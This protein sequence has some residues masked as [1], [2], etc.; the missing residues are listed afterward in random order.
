[1]PDLEGRLTRGG[2]GSGRLR[3]LEGEE[4][5]E[6]PDS[7]NSNRNLA[8]RRR[9]RGSSARPCSAREGGA[10]GGRPEVEPTQRFLI[11]CAFRR[12]R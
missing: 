8:G 2:E 6:S 10:L 9:W 12:Y 1:V 11:S 3:H 7:I 4:A 5:L